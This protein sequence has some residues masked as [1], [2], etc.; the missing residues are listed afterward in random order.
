MWRALGGS[1]M[2]IFHESGGAGVGYA[3]DDIVEGEAEAVAEFKAL[4]K[5]LDRNPHPHP[6]L[7]PNVRD[8]P[9][10]WLG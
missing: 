9:S 3:S 7:H 5:T 8:C 6:T 1:V 4:I 10:P 2:S